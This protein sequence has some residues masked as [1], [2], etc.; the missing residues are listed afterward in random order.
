MLT[1]ARDAEPL[2]LIVDQDADT[3]LLY[4]DFLQFHQ[5]RAIGAAGGPEALAIAIARRPDVVV[6]ETRL[7]GF[8]GVTL[9][10]L[11]RKDWSTA[12][13]PIIFVTS[14]VTAANLAKA[15]AA[16]GVLTKPCLPDTLLQ[17][18]EALV[19]RSH[20]LQHRAAATQA[21]ARTS[22]AHASETVD[23]VRRQRA[24]VLSL[25]NGLQRGPTVRPP[26]PPGVLR[27]PV[28]GNVMTYLRSHVGGVASHREQWDY[29]EC[30]RQCGTFEHRVRTR[31]IKKI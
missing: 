18:I 19:D 21:L 30:P 26:V 7:P 11:L 8:D 4:S 22:V 6:T 5:W 15:A 27:C 12:D 24:A 10:E 1:E 25:E 14:D 2:A 29:L 31:K 28:C 9:S 3:R 20:E 23:R 16:G 13:V 17:A